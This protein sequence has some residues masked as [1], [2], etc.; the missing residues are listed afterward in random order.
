M[1][2][3]SVP[4]LST[5]IAWAASPVMTSR[6]LLGNQRAL[7]ATPSTTWALKR[8]RLRVTIRNGRQAWGGGGGAICTYELFLL[9]SML[10]RGLVARQQTRGRRVVPLVGV[11]VERASD[12]WLEAVG[13]ADCVRSACVSFPP[14][15]LT[16]YWERPRRRD[17]LERGHPRFTL[18][19]LSLKRPEA[20]G[21]GL[22]PVS[23]AT[24]SSNGQGRP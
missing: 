17:T 20:A 5:M 23:G 8:P 3:F 18:L 21:S 4:W 24:S 6:L 15:Q 19:R 7:L 14:S 12:T 2:C 10:G 16:G 11:L 9:F 22:Y 1:R 13:R